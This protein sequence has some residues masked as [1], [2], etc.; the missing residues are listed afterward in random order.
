MATEIIET[1]K[2][3]YRDATVV[4]PDALR[5]VYSPD[6]VFVDPMHRMDGIEELAGY[7]DSMYK[8]VISCG[9]TYLDEIVADQQ[10][11]IRWD[12]RLQHKRLAGGREIVVR[13]AT[14]VQF[15]ELIVR[16][17][18]YFDVGSLLYE[19]IPVLGPCVLY[20]K[21]RLGN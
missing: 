11:S 18:D 19:N 8:N 3:M 21:N 1:F 7:F 9:F 2:H 5:A 15:N 17:E 6:I 13:G 4:T 12:M 20:L 14:F 16:H 10:A